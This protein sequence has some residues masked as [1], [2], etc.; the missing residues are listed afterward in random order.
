MTP[1]CQGP[2]HNKLVF[3]IHI[4]IQCSLKEKKCTQLRSFQG[5]QDSF[6]FLVMCFPCPQSVLSVLTVGDGKEGA[7]NCWGVY[8]LP[9]KWSIQ[10]LPSLTGAI[11]CPP[12]FMHGAWEIRPSEEQSCAPPFMH[13]AW[14]IWPSAVLCVAQKGSSTGIMVRSVV[15]PVSGL[16]LRTK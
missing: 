7:E 15:P 6:Q 14:E 11:M 13:G 10:C 1:Q 8:R 9:R 5:T 16:F 4:T 12:R 3:F 2:K